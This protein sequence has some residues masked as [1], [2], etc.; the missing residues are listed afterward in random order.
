[1]W[2]THMHRRSTYQC[3]WGHRNVLELGRDEVA[4][5]HACTDAA[6]LHTPMLHV[7]WVRIFLH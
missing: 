4:Q 1:M 2:L 3:C 7:C 5:Y 6:G